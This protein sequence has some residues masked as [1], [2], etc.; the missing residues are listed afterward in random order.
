MEDRLIDSKW[1]TV[2]GQRMDSYLSMAA[3]MKTTRSSLFTAS[4]KNADS[5]ID[6]DGSNYY[7]EENLGKRQRTD[8]RSE[9]AMKHDP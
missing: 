7:Q 3:S 8:D 9:H 1:K 6:K 5:K 2:E 4:T